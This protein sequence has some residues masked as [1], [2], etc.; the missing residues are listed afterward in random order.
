MLIYE[1]CITSGREVDA[2]W[3]S[4]PKWLTLLYIMNRYPEILN[5]ISNIISFF[6]LH[7]QVGDPPI[8][9]H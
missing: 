2:I 7:N 4:R 5:A 1:L 9:L 6:P 8:L 3:R